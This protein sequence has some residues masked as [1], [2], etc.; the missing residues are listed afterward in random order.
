MD[1]QWIVPPERYGA[2]RQH[3]RAQGYNAPFVP[4]VGDAYGDGSAVK[5]VYCGAALHHD[6]HQDDTGDDAHAYA[7]GEAE[8]RRFVHGGMYNSAFWR[9]FA[10]IAAEVPGMTGQESG[11]MLNRFVW[12]KLS[13]AAVSGASAPPNKDRGLR[14]LDVA[15][16]RHEMDVLQPNVLICTSG[17]L[18]SSTGHE[19]FS[20]RDWQAVPGFEAKTPS[21]WIRRAEWGGWLLWTM[22]PAYKPADWASL[23]VEDVR[24]ILQRVGDAT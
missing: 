14:S 16:F 7:H 2:Y 24:R 19:I 23:V 3:C 13:K 11:L 17:S 10:Q 9:L 1:R 12:T 21:S 22:H 4:Y 6:S 18:V 8:T 5:L 15:Q 20:E